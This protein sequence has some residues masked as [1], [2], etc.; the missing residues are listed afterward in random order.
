MIAA[1]VLMF[2]FLVLFW[3]VFFKF[4]WIKFS[5]AWGVISA[6]FWLHL[7]LIFVIGLR[8]ITPTSTDAKV[9]Q[10]TIQLTPRLPE[11]TLVDAVLVEPNVPV[12]RGQPLFQ[13]DRRVYEYKVRQL[14]AKL[15]Q[16]KQDVLVLKADMEASAQKVAQ[17]DAQAAGANQNVLVLKADVNVAAQ[18]VQKAKSELV[19]ARYAQQLANDLAAKGA[20]PEED[21]QKATAQLA[22]AEAGVAESEAELARATLKFDAEIGGVNPSVA[23]LNAS[24]K[25]AR[26]DL[27]RAKLRYTSEIGGVNTNVAAIQA[28]LEQARFYLDNTLMLAPEDGYVINLQVRPGMVAGEIRFGAIATFVCDAD[29]YLLAT[30]FQEN[31]KFVLPGQPVEAALDLYPGQIFRGTVLAVWQGSGAGQMLP[32]GTLPDFRAVSSEVPQGQFAVAIRIDDPDQSK[33]PIGT[34]GRAAIYTNPRSPFVVL[35][36]IG[37]RGYSWSNW[38]YPFAG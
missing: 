8:F 28:E 17:L 18:K 13:F 27:E 4:K 19:Y 37:L 21:A 30:Y 5:I 7:L 34:Q 10:H 25:E 15:A 33:F 12:K 1:L 23:A 20:G 11:P 31:L 24:I 16:A 6:F 9:I 29:R 2:G 38:I 32:S 35:R 26:A 14:E 22:V 36:K 3:L